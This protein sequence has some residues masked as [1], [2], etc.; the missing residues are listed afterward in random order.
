[1]WRRTSPNIL[2]S[3]WLLVI[4]SIIVLACVVFVRPNNDNFSSDR[5]LLIVFRN[6]EKRHEADD[7]QDFRTS[8]A[9][10]YVDHRGEWQR[11]ESEGFPVRSISTAA[12]PPSRAIHGDVTGY[13]SVPAGLYAGERVPWP[14]REGTW[15]LRLS[16]WHRN[17]GV[18]SLPHPQTLH[19]WR[20]ADDGQ[21]VE[22]V[23]VR[24]GMEKRGTYL[25]PSHT[26]IWSRGDSHGCMNLHHPLESGESPSVWDRFATLLESLGIRSD[27]ETLLILVVPADEFGATSG[28]LPSHV[29]PSVIESWKFRKEM[30]ADEIPASP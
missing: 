7:I 12:T 16:D 30:V 11:V 9:A 4:A 5:L 6:P 26:R 21:T 17:D 20:L 10:V 19:E 3:A 2:F 24:S 1:M 28:E 25:H 15:A 23:M 22:R 14:K 27:G 29:D 13:V 8:F 18:I